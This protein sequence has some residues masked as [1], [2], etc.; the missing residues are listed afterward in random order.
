MCLLVHVHTK[1]TKAHNCKYKGTCIFCLPLDHTPFVSMV[2]ESSVFLT[3]TFFA[4]AWNKV[5]IAKNSMMLTRLENS[6]PFTFIW[7]HATLES[8]M[9]S[10][11]M[12]YLCCVWVPIGG[13]T[14]RVYKPCI[15]STYL[16]NQQSLWRIC[17]NLNERTNSD[18]LI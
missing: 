6:K 4:C 1:N 16:S 11:Y 8:V 7:L 14:H 10:Y 9:F 12:I 3:Y 18:L 5:S 2:C 15:H 13:N 17:S